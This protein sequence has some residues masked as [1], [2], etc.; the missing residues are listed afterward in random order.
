MMRDIARKYKIST[1]KTSAYRFQ[2]N[3]SIERSHHVV[4]EYL[5]KWSQK[6]NWDKYVIY[7]TKAY[8]TSIH[9]GTKYT[10]H[11]LVFKRAGESLAC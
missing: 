11:E 2:S 1:Y 7:A 4:I 8:N 5:K 6:H 3:G 10:L 9:E